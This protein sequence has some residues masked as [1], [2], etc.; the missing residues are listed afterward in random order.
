[1]RI[2]PALLTL[3]TLAGLLAAPLAH[4]EPE[5]SMAMPAPAG[6][7]L[8][9]ARLQLSLGCAPWQLGCDERT[10]QSR[11]RWSV[12]LGSTMLTVPPRGLAAQAGTASA[13]SLSLV[14]RQALFGSGLS[15]YGKLGSTIAR[16]EAGSLGLAQ[17]GLGLSFGAGLAYDFG[18]RLSATVGF[19]SQELRLGGQSRELRATSLGLQWRY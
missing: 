8:N 3:S 11:L 19:D 9:P 16:P 10:A 18:P 13:T 15:V 12:E 6:L 14:G 2:R 5:A 17:G 1:M 7:G 4:A